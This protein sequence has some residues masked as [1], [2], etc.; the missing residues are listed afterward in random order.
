HRL[1]PQGDRELDRLDR[2]LAVQR[3]GLAVVAD[4]LAAPRPQIGVPPTRR[5]AEGVTGGLAK[6]PAG[7]LQFLAGVTVFVP[8]SRELAVLVADLL[9]PGFAV[10]D[11]PAAD[12]PRHADPFAVNIVD[13]LCQVVIAA[14]VLADL[15]GA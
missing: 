2:L 4:L 1:R 8:G 6:R 5:V 9:E 15:L 10:G 13:D 11:Q 12:R 7:G 14:L 3:D